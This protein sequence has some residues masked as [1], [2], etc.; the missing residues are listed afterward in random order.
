[1]KIRI[2]KIL[3]VYF[4][5]S[6]WLIKFV[7]STLVL[8]S[9]CYAYA[10]P[11]FVVSSLG[12]SNVQRSN[13]NILIIGIDDLR[14]EL[15]CYGATHI[16]SP[17]IDQ[18]AAQGTL[19]ERAYCQ[20]AVCGPS[21]SSMFTGLRPDTTNA[22]NNKT[23]FRDQLPDAVSLPEF[24]KNKGYKTYGFGKILHN[25][26][27]DPQSWSEPQHYIVEKQYASSGYEHKIAGIDGIHNSNGL[28]PLFE[29]PDVSDDAYRDGI[30]NQAA[31]AKLSDAAK[32]DQPFLL[33]MGYHKPHTPFNAPKKYWDLYDPETLPLAP[34][35]FPPAGTPEFAMNPWRYVRSFKDIPEEGPMPEPLARKTRHAYFACVS[36]IDSLI[37]ELLAALEETGEADNTIIALW[38]DHG[39][40][41]GDHGMWCKHTNFETSTHIPFIIVDPRKDVQGQRT[42]T[43]IE[44]IDMYPTLA[45][46]AGL[47]SPQNIEGKSLVPLIADPKAWDN[48]DTVAFSQFHRAGNQGYSVRTQNLRYTEWRS[49]KTGKIVAQELYDHRSDPQENVNVAGSPECK[50]QLSYA[51]SRLHQQWSLE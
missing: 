15:G 24:F 49:A 23:H 7:L 27:R 51:Q 9:F 13:P 31:I 1:M 46:I 16:H 17:N 47:D 4:C 50:E 5:V 35:P 18:L 11:P 25:T 12:L 37:G 48:Q 19:F 22:Y 45:D 2:S 10:A 30:S 26:H 20:Y 3:F 29:G 36:Y 43:R 44:L 21:R 39:Y 40:Q 14:P 41:L 28:I 6:S 8:F 34:N 33:F 32:S 38:S 42:T